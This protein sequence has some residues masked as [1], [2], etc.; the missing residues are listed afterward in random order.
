MTSE[1]IISDK[2][3]SVVPSKMDT[4]RPSSVTATNLKYVPVSLL[5]FLF[6]VGSADGQA[7]ADKR[8]DDA[9]DE[10]MVLG[11][12]SAYDSNATGIEPSGGEVALTATMAEW[13]ERVRERR[14]EEEDRVGGRERE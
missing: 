10:P 3:Y 1:E 9:C 13:S 11:R 14:G 8:E 7:R 4:Y 12:I 6:D 2:R 5:A